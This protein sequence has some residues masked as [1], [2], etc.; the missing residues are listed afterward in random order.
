MERQSDEFL[1]LATSAHLLLRLLLLVLSMHV[2]D[3][4]KWLMSCVFVSFISHSLKCKVSDVRPKEISKSAESIFFVVFMH[5]LTHISSFYVLADSTGVSVCTW[6]NI[7]PLKYF[8]GSNCTHVF[9]L[10][11]KVYFLCSAQMFAESVP[12][13]KLSSLCYKSWINFRW[14]RRRPARHIHQEVWIHL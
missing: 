6:F 1:L 10:T 7:F 11:T 3:M 4:W 12:D 9:T 13:W 5:V 14:L 2:C 8:H